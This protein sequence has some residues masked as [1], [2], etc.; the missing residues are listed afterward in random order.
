MKNNMKYTFVDSVR[1]KLERSAFK[2]FAELVR[3][4]DCRA[5]REAINSFG[6]MRSL[7]IFDQRVR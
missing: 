4:V 1:T 7:L 6:Y 3:V 2:F 5:T